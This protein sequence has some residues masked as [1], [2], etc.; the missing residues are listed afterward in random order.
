MQKRSQIGAVSDLYRLRSRAG[1]QVGSSLT[2]RP[3][4]PVTSGCEL[5]WPKHRAR[6]LWHC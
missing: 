3:E 1:I 2:H 4:A 5:F 6:S